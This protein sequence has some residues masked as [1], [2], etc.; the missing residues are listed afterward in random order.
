M[1][2]IIC[3]VAASMFICASSA[4][5]QSD[6]S[7][8]EKRAIVQ[9]VHYARGL[10]VK[11]DY[12]EGY[13]LAK[14]ML[15]IIEGKYREETALLAE[16]LSIMAEAAKKL[17]KNDEAKELS[18]RTKTLRVQKRQI[19]YNSTDPDVRIPKQH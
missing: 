5:A 1:K 13:D 18:E 7:W 6:D 14:Q 10:V 12:Q 3:L 15:A 2:K 4:T 17:G 19:N 11:G 8:K 16:T 9:E